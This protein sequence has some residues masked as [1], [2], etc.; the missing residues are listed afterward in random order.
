MC[1]IY[2]SSV[3]RIIIS[4]HDWFCYARIERAIFSLKR[5]DGLEMA[6]LLYECCLLPYV[7]NR[8][9]V[10]SNFGDSEWGAGE[11]HTRP[12]IAIAKIRDYL[13]SS[14]KRRIMKAI[15]SIVLLQ[16]QRNTYGQGGCLAW[17]GKKG[18]KSQFCCRFKPLMCFTFWIIPWVL[19]FSL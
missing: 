15:I 1:T 19:E 16:R 2:Y 6:A 5:Q 10:V 17:Q 18:Q 9:R 11:I 8:L 7:W 13:Q 4:L 3:L 14:L 12:T